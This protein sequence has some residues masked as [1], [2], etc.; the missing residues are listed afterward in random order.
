MYYDR[1]GNVRAVGAECMTP[2]NE[3]K[4]EDDGWMKV[5]WYAANTRFRRILIV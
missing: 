4:A 1:T 5:E 2:E 3:E